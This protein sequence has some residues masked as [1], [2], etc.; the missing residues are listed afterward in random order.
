M[1]TYRELYFRGT[2][3]QLTVFTDQI[4]NFATG[5]WEIK[6]RSDRWKDY[7]FFEY[8]GSI[9]DKANVSIYVGDRLIKGEL[10]VG[11]IVPIE[12][13]QLSV[14]EYNAVLMRFY[15]DVIVPY[16]EHGTDVNISQPSDD[17]FNPT[18]VISEVALEKLKLFCNAANKSTGSSHPCDRERWFDFVCQTVDDD[19]MFDYSVLSN[20]LQDEN[21][22]GKKPDEYIGVMGDYAWSEDQASELASEYD[23]MCEI[24]KYYKK[25]RGI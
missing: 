3:Q 2:L 19:R 18:S 25:T 12:K 23:S 4:G 14:D 22:W 9:V 10:S 8:H 15:E 17:I 5:D 21:Y 7:L 1:K 13:S 24:L 16:K 6:P 11:N 20:F